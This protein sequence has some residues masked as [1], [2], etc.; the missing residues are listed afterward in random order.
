MKSECVGWKPG[1]HTFRDTSCESVVWEPLPEV[2]FEIE[3]RLEAK[4]VKMVTFTV[5]NDL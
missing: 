2:V 1:I 5:L 3:S 4:F